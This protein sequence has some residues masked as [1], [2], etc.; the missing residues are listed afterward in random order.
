MLEVPTHEMESKKFGR[1]WAG[2]EK[3]G[4]AAKNKYRKTVV[5]W[6]SRRWISEAP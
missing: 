1:K 5:K 2:R 4:A 3:G 6:S